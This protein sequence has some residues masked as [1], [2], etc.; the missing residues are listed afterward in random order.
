MTWDGNPRCNSRCMIHLLM[1]YTFLSCPKSHV[2][3]IN[4]TIQVEESLIRKP[5]IVE[6]YLIILAHSADAILWL[7]FWAVSLSNIVLLY[8]YKLKSLFS[9][10]CTDCLDNLISAATFCVDLLGLL[11]SAILTGS[12]FSGERTD[13]GQRRFLSNT[14][15]SSLNW[16]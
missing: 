13:E 9:I 14:E 10:H 12:V 6:Q 4:D 2:L 16:L 8:G 3:F 7:L 11:C 5:N 15:P 1:N